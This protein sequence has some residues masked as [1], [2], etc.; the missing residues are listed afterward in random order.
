MQTTTK[1]RRLETK[2]SFVFAHNLIWHDGLEYIIIFSKLIV[3]AVLL[4]AYIIIVSNL[5]LA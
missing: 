4:N 5:I 2:R 1:A 3:V